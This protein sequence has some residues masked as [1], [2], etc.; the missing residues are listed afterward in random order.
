MQDVRTDPP[1]VPIRRS[2]WPTRRSPRWLFVA[3]GLFV[4][5]AVAV[6]IVHRP[7]AGERASDLHGL[8]GELRTDVQ[9]CSGGVGESLYV[10]RAI[11]TG[12]NHNV[13]TALNVAN[14]ASANCSPANN[15]SVEDMIDNLQVPSSLDGYGLQ[16]GVKHLIAWTAPDAIDVC[17]DVAKVLRDRGKPSEAAARAQ[18]KRARH[19]LDAQR[20]VVYADF[21]PAI[22]AIAPHSRL[23]VLHG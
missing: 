4:A 6:G 14:T 21:A 13:A 15:M 5:I 18:L 17:A 20:A 7:S 11:D 8:L 23:F 12:A 3:V 2:A 10:L 1:H 9:S 22:K 16:T 19:K